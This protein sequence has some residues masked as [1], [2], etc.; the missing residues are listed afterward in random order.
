MFDHRNLAPTVL[1]VLLAVVLWQL[2][3]GKGSVFEVAKLREKVRI[4]QIENHRLTQANHK[5][6]DEI[7]DIREGGHL[8]EGIARDELGMLKRG[9]ILV[10]IDPD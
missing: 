4:Q 7:R 6:G 1:L 9:E 3:V 2:F 10:Q 8:I 5:L